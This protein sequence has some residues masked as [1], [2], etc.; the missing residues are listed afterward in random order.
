MQEEAFYVKCRSF[1]KSG[2]GVNSDGSIFHLFT[3]ISLEFRK[4]DKAQAKNV[5]LLLPIMVWRLPLVPNAKRNAS[6]F[7]KLPRKFFMELWYQ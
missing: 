3:Y 7:H 6:N 1:D 5:I 4:M 2:V